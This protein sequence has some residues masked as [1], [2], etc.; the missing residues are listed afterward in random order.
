MC[1]VINKSR[2]ATRDSCEVTCHAQVPDVSSVPCVSQLDR[3]LRHFGE[4]SSK[5]P[6]EFFGIFDSF[7]SAFSE[8]RQA[9]EHM[10]RSKEEEKRRALLEAQVRRACP[11]DMDS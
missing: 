5:E 2:S 9:N 6:D 8:A 1:F 7:L 10:A 11:T 3:A 4:D